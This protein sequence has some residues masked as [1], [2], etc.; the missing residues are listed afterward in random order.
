MD[1]LKGSGG[2][3]GREKKYAS[4]KLN[5]SLRPVIFP[6][7]FTDLARTLEKKQYEPTVEFPDVGLG[8]RVGG[9][10]RI[11][12]KGDIFVI[13]DSDRQFIGIEGRTAK[14]VLSSFENLA[15]ILK[16]D[17]WVDVHGQAGYYEVITRMHVLAGVNPTVAIGRFFDGLAGVKD[18]E[19]IMGEPTALFSLRLISK[20]KLPSGEEWFDIRIEPDAARPGNTYVIEVVYRKS[21][22]GQVKSFVNTI[23]QKIDAM[24]DKL[25]QE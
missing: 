10:G 21:D 12:K 17:L 4:V 5:A 14:D 23:D 1:E 15:Q 16:D 11:A 22:Y 13:A 9:S 6:I 25:E 24:L 18:L 7:D 3:P 2:M 8:K 19:L 20:G